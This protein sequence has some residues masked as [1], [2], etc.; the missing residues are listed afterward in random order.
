M[1]RTRATD[2]FVHQPC[3]DTVAIAIAVSQT[4]IEYPFQDIIYNQQDEYVEDI[5]QTEANGGTD[6]TINQLLKKDSYSRAVN[7][8]S[9][10]ISRMPRC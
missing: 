4:Y 2:K 7:S 10:D 1:R 6:V 9:R 5:T 8:L 3:Y